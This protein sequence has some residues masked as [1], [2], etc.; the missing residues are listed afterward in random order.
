MGNGVL[1]TRHT[2][3]DPLKA[4][5]DHLNELTGIGIKIFLSL[6]SESATDLR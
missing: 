5:T 6:K 3:A 2:L 4:I 1:I